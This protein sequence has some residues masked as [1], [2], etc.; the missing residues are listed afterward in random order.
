M[1]LRWPAWLGYDVFISYMHENA[2]L[3]STALFRQLEDSDVKCFFDDEEAPA[4][5]VLDP[6]LRTA[7]AKSRLLVLI[8]TPGAL[9]RV[10]IQ[11][12]LEYFLHRKRPGTV[13]PIDVDRSLQAHTE[14]YLILGS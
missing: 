5:T 13:I 3:Y 7:V 14:R 12:E 4:G 11:S 2:R 6:A 1:R 10:W 9:D 8:A